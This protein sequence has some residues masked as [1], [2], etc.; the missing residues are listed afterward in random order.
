MLVRCREVLISW[1][2]LASVLQSSTNSC[3]IFLRSPNPTH[4]IKNVCVHWYEYTLRVFAF[5]CQ[6][7]HLMY[8]V[9]C[10]LLWCYAYLWAGSSPCIYWLPLCSCVLFTLFTCEACCFERIGIQCRKSGWCVVV[11]APLSGFSKEKECLVEIGCSYIVIQQ[12]QQ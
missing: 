9:Y 8:P 2:I 6:N 3:I 11:R 10:L 7:M 5:M 12:Q 4:F 1:D